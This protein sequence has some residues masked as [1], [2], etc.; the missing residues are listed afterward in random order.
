MT[1]KAALCKALLDGR[2][3]NIKNCF[4]LIGLTNCPREVSRMVEQSFGV[5]VTRINREGKSRYQHP[6]IWVDY[7][8]EKSEQNLEGIK[9]MQEYVEKELGGFVIK[10]DKQKKQI[11]KLTTN[12]LFAN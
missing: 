12:P 7:K 3:L 6:V 8:L 5:K 10:T 2:T 1:A 9:K 4:D 11:D